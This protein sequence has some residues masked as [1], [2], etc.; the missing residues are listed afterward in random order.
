MTTLH[1]QDIP[2]DGAPP[3]CA[4]RSISDDDLCASCQH[5]D[6]RPGH[7][8]ACLLSVAGV[9]T[10]LQ[11]WMQTAT[12]LPVAAMSVKNRLINMAH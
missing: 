9:T 5:L 8:S 3:V 2:T 11:N 6:Y 7:L 10:G 12:A 4:G 1:I